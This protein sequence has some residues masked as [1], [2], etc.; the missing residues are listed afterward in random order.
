MSKIKPARRENKQPSNQRDDQE[1]EIRLGRGRQAEEAI[2]QLR[3]LARRQIYGCGE[4]AAIYAEQK[5]EI[6][7]GR[8]CALRKMRKCVAAYFSHRAF[9]FSSSSLCVAHK[10]DS[11]PVSS[12]LS[13]ESR[14]M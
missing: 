13:L 2:E 12:R 10:R 14:A 4:G 7:D 9:P 1:R 11:F 5:K 3:R 8:V 6:R